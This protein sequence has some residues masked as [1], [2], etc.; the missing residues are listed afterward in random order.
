MTE[1]ELMLLLATIEQ[2]L[3]ACGYQRAGEI[4]RHAFLEAIK[5]NHNA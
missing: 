1:F 3:L 2:R 5:E 4:V